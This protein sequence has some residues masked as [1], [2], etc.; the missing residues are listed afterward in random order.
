[1][2]ILFAILFFLSILKLFTM[3][4]IVAI[5]FLCYLFFIIQI[6]N[7]HIDYKIKNKSHLLTFFMMQN[8]CFIGGSLCLGR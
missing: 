3:E 1:M 4:C 8:L 6:Q 2:F 7:V 5:S